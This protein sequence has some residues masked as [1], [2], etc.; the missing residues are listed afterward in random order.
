MQHMWIYG[1]H[2]EHKQYSIQESK[3][4]LKCVVMVVL[5]IMETRQYT[6]TL[7]LCMYMYICM[8]GNNNTTP[9]RGAL[10]LWEPH[11]IVYNVG[12]GK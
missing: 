12:R 8:A 6:C 5:K 9:L 10:P 2:T 1:I 7:Y 11:P 3:Q 4:M